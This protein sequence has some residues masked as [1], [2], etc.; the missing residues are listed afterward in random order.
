MTTTRDILRALDRALS[1]VKGWS[2][3]DPE[4]W[5]ALPEWR[6]EVVAWLE[7]FDPNAAREFRDLVNGVT[8]GD[9]GYGDL[10][11]FLQ[12]VRGDLKAQSEIQETRANRH[13]A[14]RLLV[15]FRESLEH[16][17]P[18]VGPA[19]VA[20]Y[21]G[22]LTRY[23]GAESA[24]YQ[25]HPSETD[26]NF[27]ELEILIGRV[28]QA[29]ADLEPEPGISAD[30]RLHSTEGEVLPGSIHPEISAAAGALFS[31]GHHSDVVSAAAKKLIKLV[32]ERSGRSDLDTTDLMNVVFSP[33]NP[34]LV[35]NERQTQSQKDEQEGLYFLHKGAVL[36]VRNPRAHDFLEDSPERALEYIG[37]IS[38]LANRLDEAELT[39]DRSPKRRRTPGAPPV[40]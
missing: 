18:Y 19:K 17:G 7:E 20:R 24:T 39:N 5:E 33:K 15:Q 10:E 1:Q 27:T 37:L 3:A 34:V 11:D 32:Q 30:L 2:Q 6:S 13:K 21:H 35:F 40:R 25:I 9:V 8:T 12:G 14:L 28:D 38:L 4:W 16:D 26:E 29:M 31:N 22:I 36:G 23:L